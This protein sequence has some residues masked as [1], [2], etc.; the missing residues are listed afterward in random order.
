[1]NLLVVEFLPMIHW[2]VR[3]LKHLVKQQSGASN[4]DYQM[5]LGGAY[6]DLASRLKKCSYT[7]EQTS[8]NATT[9]L[10]MKF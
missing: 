4:F 9:L 7:L 2:S 1:M 3:C 5:R 6:Y 10:Q 8:K